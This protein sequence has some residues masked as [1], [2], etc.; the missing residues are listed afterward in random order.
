MI[1]RGLQEIFIQKKKFLCFVDAKFVSKIT[2]CYAL[3]LWSK[4]STKLL[5]DLCTGMKWWGVAQ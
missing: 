4:I 3:G 2:E 1:D 5:S